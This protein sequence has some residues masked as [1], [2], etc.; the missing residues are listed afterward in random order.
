MPYSH[1]QPLTREQALGRIAHL[2]PGALAFAGTAGFI[3]SVAL[4]V[5]NSPVSHM[6]GALS[7]LGIELAAGHAGA[8]LA[9]CSIILAFM[10]GAAAAGLIIGAHELAPGRR[11]GAAV[12]GEGALLLS[13][14]VLLLAGRHAGVLLIA[15]ACGLQNATT[16][17]YCGLMIRTTHVTGTVTD[18]GVMLGHWLRHRHV[19]RRKLALMA[20]LVLAFG[21]GVWIGALA[22]GRWGP[23]CLAIPAGGCLLAGATLAL[24]PGRFARAARPA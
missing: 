20:G 17:S 18:L 12:L 21:T 16:S 23:G 19:E 2:L 11:F 7:Y 22:N 10:A 13:A 9:T 1:P 24:F 4:G 8:A 6:T 5:F 3:N 15:V 14:M